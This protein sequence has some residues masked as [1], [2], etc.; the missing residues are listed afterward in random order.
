ME[1]TNEG[2][3]NWDRTR[4]AGPRDPFLDIKIVFAKL[5][6]EEENKIYIFLNF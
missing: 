2:F 1:F 3:E 4:N 6:N 5:Q